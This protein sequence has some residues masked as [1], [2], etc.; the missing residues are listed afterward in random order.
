MIPLRALIV[1]DDT[2]WQEILGELLTDNGLSVDTVSTLEDTLAILKSCSHRLAVVDLSLSDGEPENID[3][4]KVLEIIRRVDPNTHTILLTGFATVELA[5]SAMTEHGAVTVL[6]KECFARDEFNRLVQRLLISAPAQPVSSHQALDGGLLSG[7]PAEPMVG[8]ALVVDDD[9][10]WQN[11]L[12]DLLT[13]AGYQT[14][15]CSSFGEASGYLRRDTRMALA[16]I[17]LSLCGVWSDHRSSTSLEDMEGYYLL[18]STQSIGLPTIVVSGM[19]AP[20]DIQRLY[21]ERGIFAYVEK[22]TFDRESFLQLV[23][24]VPKA[25]QVDD[26]LARLTDREYEV[27]QRL[28]G[29]LTNKEIA[30]KLVITPNTVKRHLKAIFEK[31]TVS[32]RA[33]AVAKAAEKGIHPTV[34]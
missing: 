27:L 8:M 21:G 7:V 3:G 25:P 4:L 32:T 13:E 29:G 11:L 2:A 5:V 18:T 9:P 34:Q 28:V 16:V 15:R 24:Q 20:A 26:T 1:E 33:A 31:L 12:A 10:G 6:R 17:D 30:Q 22:Q 23:M 14:R 19:T